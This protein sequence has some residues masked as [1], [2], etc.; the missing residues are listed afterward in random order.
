MSIQK[1]ASKINASWL[2]VEAPNNFFKICTVPGVATDKNIPN[3]H[4]NTSSFNADPDNGDIPVVLGSQ[5]RNPYTIDN[6]KQASF[7][8]YGSSSI[9]HVTDLYVRFRPANAKAVNTAIDLKNLRLAQG[10][11]IIKLTNGAETLTGKLVVAK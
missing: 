11:Y 3:A 10:I 2:N 1:A 9:I 7:R 5:L 4:Q 6:M 8:L